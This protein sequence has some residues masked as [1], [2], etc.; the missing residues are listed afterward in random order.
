MNDDQSGSSLDQEALDYHAKPAPGK[1]EIA[2]TKPLSS[3]RDLSLAYTPGVAAPCEQILDNPKKAFD[4]T[5]RKNLVGVVTNGTA[6][7]GLGDTGP[8]AS[9]PVME[10]KALL[11]KHLAGVDAFDIELDTDS[12]DS[13]VN[14]VRALEPTFGAIN[15]EDISAPECFE[16][17]ERLC[18]ELDI[19]VF[20]DDQHGT[21][22]I[23]GAA[24]LNALELQGKRLEDVRIVFAGAGAAGIACARL[25][26]TLGATPD[27]ILMCDEYGVIYK[28]RDKGM[29]AYMRPFAR[30]T[31]LRTLEEAMKGADVFIGVS[32][33][34]IVSKQMVRSMAERP[35]IFALANPEPEI[36]YPDAMDARGDLIMATGR[37]DYPNQVNNVMGY[38]YIFRGAL[39]VSATDINDEMKIAAVKGLAELAKQDI[40]EEVSDAY[41]ADYFT[42]GPDYILPK[43]FDPR[44]L[45]HIAPAVAKAAVETGVARQSEKKL[46][47]YAEQLERMQSPSK[48]LIR[49]LIN[50]AK[51]SET[52]IVFP[53]GEAEDILRAAHRLLDE[54]IAKPILMG[55]PEVISRKAKHLELELGEATLFDHHTDP[56]R[57]DTIERFYEMRQRKGVTLPE[58]EGV[59]KHRPYYA[60]MMLNEQRAD[61]VVSGL[62]A[63]YAESIRPALEIIGVSQGVQR[64]SGAYI[65]V[66]E[67]G[68]KFFAD[69]TVNIAPSPQTLAEIAINTAELAKTFDIEPRVAMLSYS[70]FGN[71]GHERATD[72]AEATRIVKQR[73][74]DI[75][76]DGEMQVGVALD[77]KLR[78]ETFDFAELTDDANILIFPNLDAGN[79]AY[80]LVDHLGDAELIGPVLLGMNKPVNILQR[81]CGVTSVVNLAVI[82]ALRAQSSA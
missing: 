45:L 2:P 19:P 54:G 29:H 66:T 67:S 46:D 26:Q 42:F 17:E 82:T 3:Q 7:L 1:F 44:A 58:A 73:R 57:Q 76:V 5:N 22:I 21:A 61:A 69:T 18:D 50:K 35:I 72:V 60:M 4:Y 51:Q 13:F 81:A 12:T 49:K 27:N 40:P 68:V 64:A 43:P 70:N 25:Y 47:E 14:S 33:G 24:L 16:I 65:A 62:Q 52:E 48:G 59:M 77:E 63:S 23:T 56:K 75:E 36:S 32:V 9:K 38:P 11:F 41:D 28:G 37:S 31:E 53:D 74:S 6:T 79:I 34:G 55:R 39:D 10:G 71:S 8:L 15:L 78:R 20:H 80:K 30:E